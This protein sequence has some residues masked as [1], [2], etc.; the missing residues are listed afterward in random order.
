MHSLKQLIWRACTVLLAAVIGT[1]AF[2]VL[3]VVLVLALLWA[4]LT[5]TVFSLYCIF[6]PRAA[7][8]NC[9]LKLTRNGDFWGVADVQDAFAAAKLSVTHAQQIAIDSMA[10]SHANSHAGD[11]SCSVGLSQ[12]MQLSNAGGHISFAAPEQPASAPMPLAAGVAPV[13]AADP[14]SS[15]SNGGNENVHITGRQVGQQQQQLI[16]EVGWGNAVL[17]LSDDDGG[18]NTKQ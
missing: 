3:F 14:A 16:G 7:D 6:I 18:S 15:S 11:A 2:V 4:W 1:A 8:S 10:G 5:R 9:C 17:K 13:R 12:A